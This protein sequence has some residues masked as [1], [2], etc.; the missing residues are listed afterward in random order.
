M[1]FLQ[2]PAVASN[3]A[4]L[5][6]D[7]TSERLVCPFQ[8]CLMAVNFSD[9]LTFISDRCHAGIF[10]KFYPF[11]LHC[12]LCIRYSDDRVLGF[13]FSSDVVAVDCSHRVRLKAVQNLVTYLE[14][15]IHHFSENSFFDASATCTPLFLYHVADTS[16]KGSVNLFLLLQY[17]FHD[18]FQEL[19]PIEFSWTRHRQQKHALSCFSQYRSRF[20]H[21]CL[22]VFCKALL[23]ASELLTSYKH[24]SQYV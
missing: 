22:L 15:C 11:S 2:I 23:L 19:L 8:I 7:P 5:Q 6:Q 10:L 4:D 16:H 12:G 14:A 21:R 9:H 18:T 13:S 20:P 1:Q 17:D 24:C 3:G